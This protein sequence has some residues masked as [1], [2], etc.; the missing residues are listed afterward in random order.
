MKGNET[1]HSRAWLPQETRV[2]IA[3]NPAFGSGKH[4]LFRQLQRASA[5]GSLLALP[6]E[7]DSFHLFD[8]LGNIL[9]CFLISR[10]IDTYRNLPYV[11]P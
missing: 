7:L 3:C 6:R 11:W 8:H 2:G 4:A 9:F 5:L 1:C 10:M